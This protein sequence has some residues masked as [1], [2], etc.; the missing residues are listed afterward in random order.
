[1]GKRGPMP[2]TGGRP[3]K[4]LTERIAN[5]NP[6]GRPIMVMPAP[7]VLEGVEVPEPNKYIDSVQKDGSTLYAREI[8]EKNMEVA[9]GM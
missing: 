3:K 4:A 5:G 9:C 2:G 8:Y 7:T 1:M 6:S